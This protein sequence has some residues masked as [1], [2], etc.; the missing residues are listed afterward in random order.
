MDPNQLYYAC[1]SEHQ[2]VLLDIF[3]LIQQHPTSHLA[4][5]ALADPS[6]VSL[7]SF[8]TDNFCTKALEALGDFIEHG[9]WSEELVTTDLQALNNLGLPTVSPNPETVN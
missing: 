6:L 4:Q 2:L 7:D 9:V 1:S 8:L 3:S 5:L